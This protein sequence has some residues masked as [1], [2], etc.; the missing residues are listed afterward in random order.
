LGFPVVVPG[1][2]VGE[3][4]VELLDVPESSFASEV[5]RVDNQDIFFSPCG[6]WSEIVGPGGQSTDKRSP[7]GGRLWVEDCPVGGRSEFVL[8]WLV[9]DT[10]ECREVIG[11]DIPENVYAV[12]E[13]GDAEGVASFGE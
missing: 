11:K 3:T 5:K 6:D 8:P 12:V 10:S 2:R 7:S 9:I 13:V 1:G 4:A